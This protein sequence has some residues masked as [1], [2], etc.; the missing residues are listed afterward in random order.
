MASSTRAFRKEQLRTRTRRLFRYN[1]RRRRLLRFCIFRVP[2]TAE[3]RRRLS[4]Y[5]TDS[6]QRRRAPPRS[7]SKNRRT[8]RWYVSL[9]V[10]RAARR[11]TWRT[12]RIRDYRL[13]LRHYL[14]CFA[15]SR[16]RNLPP[17]REER[18]RLLK[19]KGANDA[20]DDER[21]RPQIGAPRLVGRCRSS[22]H[23]ECCAERSEDIWRARERETS[24]ESEK[25][26]A[27]TRKID[28]RKAIRGKGNER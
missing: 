25:R 3:F 1:A 21:S 17:W 20:N 6:Q 15:I 26:T 19:P 10:T 28:S 16:D 7:F 5:S 2:C 18:R 8:T 4:S 14:T 22:N 11:V 24:G 27:R 13:R 23:D 12:E 9:F